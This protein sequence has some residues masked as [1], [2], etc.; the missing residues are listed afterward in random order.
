MTTL[1][2]VDEKKLLDFVYRVVGDVGAAMSGTL[3]LI[4]EKLGL[5]K[6]MAEAGPVTST[7]LAK[8]TGTAE[9]Y[10]REWLGNQTAGGY[11]FYDAATGKY[12]L[13]PEHALCLVN[14]QSPVFLLGA[15]GILKAMQKSE[16]RA[17]ENFRTGAGLEWGAHHPCLFD[18]TE[19]FFR[20]AYNGHLI[21]DWIPALSGV[22]EKLERGATVADIGCG[23]GASTIILAQ[24]FPK[25]TFVGFDYHEAS[26]QSARERAKAA[27]VDRRVTFQVAKSTTFGGGPYDLVCSFDCLHDME[28]PAGCAKHV[29]RSLASDGT[30]MIVE[31]IAGDRVED[32]V[33]PVS[34]VYY[35]ASTMLCVPHSLSAGG[36]ALGAQAGEA[37][38]RNVIVEQGGLSSVR[39]A[40]ETPFNIVLEAKA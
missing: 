19:R 13:P 22:K 11:V 34:R 1:Q 33:N 39:R 24:A 2:T 21:K 6:A 25:S 26:I 30:W 29:R 23:H 3:V 18:G 12:S 10:V 14:E 40:T 31:P 8:L 15:F 37:R 5:Y 32:N 28:D 16:D 20:S 7:E 38:L 17:V 4:G 27:G 36:P 35:A 9:R